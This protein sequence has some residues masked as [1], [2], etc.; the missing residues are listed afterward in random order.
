MTSKHKYR[1]SRGAVGNKISILR[2]EG[3]PEKQS[4]AMALNMKREGR[5]GAH[6]EYYRSKKRKMKRA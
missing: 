4:V 5:L 2:H 3:I 6:G 1:K